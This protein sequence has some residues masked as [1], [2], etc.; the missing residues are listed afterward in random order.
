MIPINSCIR[1]WHYL[2]RIRKCDFVLRGVALL[3]EV[4]HYGW[5]L[6]F[7][8]LKIGILFFC[9]SVS[10]SVSLPLSF[11]LC[12]MPVDPDL[13][14]QLLLQHQVCRC[15]TIFLSMMIMH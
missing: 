6:E 8:M 10:V 5:H 4:C 1:E 12:L 11:S 7:Y 14:R 2:S 3:E 9:L 13:E 15:A